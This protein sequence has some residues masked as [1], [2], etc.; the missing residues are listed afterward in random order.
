MPEVDQSK[1]DQGTKVTVRLSGKMGRKT[2]EA[3]GPV[4]AGIFRAR[5]GNDYVICR[6][7]DV[8]RIS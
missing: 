2:V 1:I 5:D 8:V 7:E 4:R 6:V 3:C